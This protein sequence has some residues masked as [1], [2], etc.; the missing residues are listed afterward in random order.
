MYYSDEIIEQVRAANPV[1]DVIGQ[2][3]QLQKKGANYFG[4]CPFHNEKSPS[5]SVSPSKQMYYCFGCG[6][7]GNVLTFIMEYENYTF[8]EAVKTLADR[9]GIAL[10]EEE[11]T[12]ERQKEKDL[13]TQLMTM[14]KDAAVFYVH[15]LKRPEGAPG[16]AYL[17]KRGISDEMIRSFGLG[18]AGSRPDT[19]YRYLKQKGYSDEI[20]RE[21]GLVTFREKGVTDKFWNRVMFPIMDANS[22]VIGFGGRVM[23][24][25]EPKYLNS[26][27]TRIFDKSRN[28]YGLNAA[29]RS[30]E[31]YM[32]VCEGYMDVIT[33]HQYGFTNAVASL[34][35]AFTSQHGMLLKR[36]TDEVILTFDSDD[37]GQKAAIRAIPVLKE[38]GLKI[39]VLNM[40]PHK[41]PDEFLRALGPEEYR[42]RIEKAENSFL[43]EIRVLKKDYD[44]S[45]P[46][47]K[48][49]F[50]NETARR[51]AGFSNEIERNTYA[52]AVSSLYGISYNVLKE[53]ISII[54]NQG[55][56]RT[57]AE[58]NTRPKSSV[59][60]LRSA[61]YGLK[62]A[63]KL[64]LTDICTDP[65]LF[66]KISK[67]LASDDFSEGLGRETAD[68]VFKQLEAGKPDPAKV[69][70][71]FIDTDQYRE[72]SELFASSYADTLSEEEH[73][74]ALKEAVLRVR[75]QSLDRKINV[76]TDPNEL[77]ELLREKKELADIR[78]DFLS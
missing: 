58:E 57:A 78:P 40:S 37:A 2:Y 31:K 56:L 50:F 64:I 22:R 20:L 18:Y 23:G 41:D 34:G 7:G 71:H 75:N 39:R 24:S 6:A 55:P 70:D 62:E 21:S 77:M 63:E 46:E 17:R 26:P 28:L 52:E 29:R 38:A 51:I 44:F 74:Q 12:P 9:A 32:L 27:E 47:D 14:H 15:S 59:K 10:P 8:Q 53:Q 4:L 43:F 5:F 67:I 60:K 76:C 68:I 69:L 61:E 45:D 19:L 1:V 72:V 11:Y 54:G 3:V 42:K 49:A 35:T 16:L 66:A 25:G 73:A 30:R 33:L 36:Y 65:A 13:R 48:A